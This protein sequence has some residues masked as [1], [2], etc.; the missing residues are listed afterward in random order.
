[1]HSRRTLQ[2]KISA[3]VIATGLFLS[4]TALAAPSC[5]SFVES[6]EKQEPNNPIEA[7]Q[8]RLDAANSLEEAR[9]L[10]YE[11]VEVAN[12]IF[13]QAIDAIIEINQKPS[14]DPQTAQQQAHQVQAM[15][16][17]LQ[18]GFGISSFVMNF[19]VSNR[20]QI[21]SAEYNRMVVADQERR[22]AGFNRD[23]SSESFNVEADQ[24]LPLGFELKSS[25]PAKK[26]FSLLFFEQ[27]IQTLNADTN[28]DITAKQPVGFKPPKSEPNDEKPLESAGFITLT[29]NKSFDQSD[30]PEVVLNVEHGEFRVKNDP[31]RQPVG[32]N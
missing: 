18:N 22:A 8:Q 7:V 30:L 2:L 3:A 29:E 14:P 28:E 4:A 25:Q 6:A 26:S 5:S 11:K 27:F 24:K 31:T 19:A 17:A 32:F 9:E 13:D 10:T 16:D 12:L 21:E 20:L 23:E 1:M 15:F